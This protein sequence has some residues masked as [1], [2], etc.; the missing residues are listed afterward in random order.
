MVEKRTL[1]VLKVT[2][3]DYLT[4]KRSFPYMA[5]TLANET[6]IMMDNVTRNRLYTKT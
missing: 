5:G 2:F 6:H 1:V 4:H 3:S